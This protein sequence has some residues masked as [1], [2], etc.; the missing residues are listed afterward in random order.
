MASF[1]PQDFDPTLPPP[2]P[3]TPPVRR[4]FVLV[5]LVLCFLAALV[6]GIPYVAERTGY[7]WEAGR[8]QAAREALA[9]LDEAGVV[10]RASA[11]FRM[12]TVAVSPAV[13]HIQSRHFGRGNGPAAAGPQG[14]SMEIG[15]GF[16]IDK[17]NG[18]IVTNQHVVKDADRIIVRLSE[19]NEVDAKVVGEDPQ[20][21]LAVIRVNTPLKVAAQWGDSDKL[22]IGDWVLAIGSPYMLD[23]SVTA[24]IISATGRNNLPIPNTDAETY[25]D[26]LQTD[27]AINPGNSGGPLI[28]LA[29]KVVGINTAIYTSQRGGSEGIGLAIPSNLARPVVEGIIKQR[30]VI[31]GYLGVAIQD[32]TPNL[33]R[34]LNVPDGTRGSLV[35]QVQ[36]GSPAAKAGIQTGDVIVKLG[37]KDVPDPVSLR[38]L[39]A[40]SEIGAQLP[41]E[42]YREGKRRTL[43]VT[44]GEQPAP[45]AVESLGF[46]LMPIRPDPRRHPEGL[47]VIDQVVDESP[48][49]RAGLRPGMLI[50][51][52]GQ[53]PV[54][55][56]AEYDKAA[57]AY[58]PDQGIPLQVML[59]PSTEIRTVV[60]RRGD[61]GP[62]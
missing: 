47:L 49:F 43:T 19:K 32:L 61:R 16:V 27:A 15:S 10:N 5:L 31:R 17:D 62:R 12:A 51:G 37:D 58:Q 33:A 36:P 44:I 57:S 22:D 4:G 14:D 35:G 52:V 9:K 7:A 6:Y 38:N 26:F 28:N 1:E 40:R 2:R 11:L 21:D 3:T 56:K 24:G 46:R 41:V 54:H 18:Y 50:V 29:G 34:Q 53:T 59:P 23:H 42:V 48:A 25:Q 45:P 55:T 60:V 20:T 8:A 30:R 39:T 13:V